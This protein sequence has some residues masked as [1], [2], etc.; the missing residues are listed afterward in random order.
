[1]KSIM[2]KTSMAILV[3]LIGFTACKTS[4]KS[5]TKVSSKAPQLE[6]S[7]LWKI[8]GNGI[9]PSYLYGTI[10]LIGKSDFFINQPT[11]DAFA[12]SEQIIMELDM[13]DPKMAMEMMTLAKM[14]NGT[15]LDKLLSEEE[16]K[17]VDE[18]L[19]SSLGAG[20]GM[21]N[22]WQPM[23]LSGMIATKYI[24]GTP[25]S[26]ESS[27][28]KMATDSNKEILGLESVKDQLDAMGKI[29]YKDQAKL[30]MEG[31]KEFDEAKEIF[32]KLVGHYKKQDVSALY[33]MMTEQYGGI[34][35]TASLLDER[36]KKWIPKIGTM[37]KEKSTFF[38]VGSGHLGGPLGVIQLL[39]NAG[40]RVTAISNNG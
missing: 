23:L 8:E 24:E 22:S 13:D 36:N 34:D 38:A 1:M 25:E 30:L 16:Y 32:S 5:V 15:T 6:N 3:F 14:D 33:E 40:Y 18:A 27:F 11:K 9:Q 35:I 7:L 21:F 31:I 2:F 26:Y 20:V 19:K 10:H 12:N 17:L 39:R 29:S 37:A 4:Q 28:M